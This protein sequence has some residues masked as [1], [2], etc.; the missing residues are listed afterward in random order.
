MEGWTDEGGRVD[1]VAF[2]WMT[3]ANSGLLIPVLSTLPLFLLT[4]LTVAIDAQV[5]ITITYTH[6]KFIE[7]KREAAGTFSE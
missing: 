4:N 5:D 3:R 1:G 7:E 6:S 2:A